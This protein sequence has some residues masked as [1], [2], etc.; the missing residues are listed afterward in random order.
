MGQELLGIKAASG[1]SR[2]KLE[3]AA[4]SVRNVV[5]PGAGPS[6]PAEGVWLF[7]NLDEYSV[8]VRG[9]K[10]PIVPQ[11]K[12]LPI[13]VEAMTRY[14]PSRHEIRVTFSEYGYDGLEKGTPHFRFT[15]AH[16]VGHAVLHA[17]DLVRLTTIPHAHQALTRRTHAH[18]IYE[19]TEWQANGFAG[20]LLMPAR[21]LAELESEWGA[22][23]PELVADRFGV[24][25]PAAKVRLSIFA[26]KRHELLRGRP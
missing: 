1:Q 4:T 21:G 26:D 8:S 13:G 7:E 15:L 2:A 3:R 24:S 19:D 22:L 16:E 9:R 23:R 11:V 12:P 17:V 6:A 5:M 20:A 25:V 14:S 18:K 10:I